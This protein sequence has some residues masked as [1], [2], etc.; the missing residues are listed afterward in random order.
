LCGL[1]ERRLQEYSPH[2][3][4]LAA[5]RSIFGELLRDFSQTPDEPG[6]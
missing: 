4:A 6:K 3:E 1:V 2:N 5:L